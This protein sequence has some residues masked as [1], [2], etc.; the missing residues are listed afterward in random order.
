MVEFRGWRAFLLISSHSANVKT[1]LFSFVYVIYHHWILLVWLNLLF[2][3]S[4][5][6]EPA[7]N[8]RSFD[9]APEDSVKKLCFVIVVV[10]SEPNWLGAEGFL[11]DEWLCQQ[12]PESPGL[13]ALSLRF[14]ASGGGVQHVCD[15]HSVIVCLACQP[16]AF[17][18]SLMSLFIQ[19]GRSF[20]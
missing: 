10:V 2:C 17:W 12:G 20:W 19:R 18:H 11:W 1:K 8:N 13:A 7:L 4:D 3:C 16:A 15:V 9:K 14:A 5:L 6:R